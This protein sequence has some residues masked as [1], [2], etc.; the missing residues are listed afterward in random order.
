MKMEI[1]TYN[2]N[3]NNDYYNIIN[4]LTDVIL[5]KAQE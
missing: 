5:N 3:I 2:L 1:T 4:K